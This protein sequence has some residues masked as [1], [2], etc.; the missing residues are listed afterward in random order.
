VR[1][2]E[3][4]HKQAPA[5]TIMHRA[6]SKK[7]G[8][9]TINKYDLPRR[10]YTPVPTTAPIVTLVFIDKRMRV[11]KRKKVGEQGQARQKGMCSLQQSE[12]YIGYSR[13]SLCHADPESNLLLTI[14]YPSP[15]PCRPSS[16]ISLAHAVTVPVFHFMFARTAESELSS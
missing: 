5:S 15:P 14:S 11:S 10:T 8:A 12:H 2:Q 6:K 16:F 3:N 4:K 7:K 9:W 13:R 1:N